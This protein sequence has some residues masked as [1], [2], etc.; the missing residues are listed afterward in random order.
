MAFQEISRTSWKQKTINLFSHKCHINIILK[1]IKIFSQ[2][3]YKNNFIINTIL[4][5]CN[6]YDIIFIQEP[7]W[8]SIHFIPSLINKEG[9]KLI[10]VPNYSNWIMFSR[11]PTCVGNSPRVITYINIRMSY[12]WFSLQKDIFDYRDIFCIFFFNCGLWIALFSN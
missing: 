9:K 10:G 5:T 7:S 2:N 11:N 3:V 1:N 12:L 8:S 4:V 6:L